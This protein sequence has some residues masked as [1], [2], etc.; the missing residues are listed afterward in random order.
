MNVDAI[1]LNFTPQSLV[2]LNIILGFVMFGIAID[3]K[4]GDF[5]TLIELP[6]SA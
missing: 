5:K 6:R 1:A 2:L 3:L 4:V